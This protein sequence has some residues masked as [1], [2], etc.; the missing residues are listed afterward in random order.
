MRVDGDMMKWLRHIACVLA[1]MWVPL[2]NGQPFFFPDTTSYVRAGD[3][4]VYIA[5]RGRFST[6]WSKEYK[7]AIDRRLGRPVLGGEQLSQVRGMPKGNDISSGNIMSGRSPYFGILLYLSYVLSDFWIFVLLQ[8]IV[9]YALILLSL[10]RFDLDQPRAVVGVV[11]LCA[12]TVSLPFYNGLLLAD[13]LAGFGILAFLLLATY[14]GEPRWCEIGFLLM[15]LAMSVISHLTHLVMLLA[16]FGA[17]IVAG[18]VR[19]NWR[20]SRLAVLS[21]IGAGAVGFASLAITSAIVQQV[22]HKP[23]QLVP[24]MTARFI[25]DGPGADFVRSGC[26][27]YDFLACKKLP[28]VISSS[29]YLWATDS[30]HGM[31]MLL[32]SE[33]RFRM[34]AEDGRFALAVFRAYPIRQSAMIFYNTA[35]QLGTFALAGLNTGCFNLPG[36][37]SSLP[38]GIRGQLTRTLSGRN[39][40]PVHFLSIWLYGVVI[41]SI[42]VIALILVPLRRKLPVAGA[43]L[44]VWLVLAF[45]AILTCSIFGGAISEPQ[46]RYQGRLIWLVPFLAS[47][48][49][50]LWR[51]AINSPLEPEAPKADVDL[52]TGTKDRFFP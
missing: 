11:A 26:G 32:P 30:R 48:T 29:A 10:R 44:M 40:W 4:A 5:S 3:M 14:R 35:K 8:A 13:A 24:L 31:Y 51:R 9:S 18:L 22:F 49:F 34:A 43:T 12:A 1:L 46:Y 21:G 36:C 7:S 6:V 38:D 27:G 20:P 15:V 42:L 52:I 33:Q 41:S 2:A 19:Q 17:M 45:I 16:M 23:P 25:A 28:P 37:W 39:A 47:I 50:L